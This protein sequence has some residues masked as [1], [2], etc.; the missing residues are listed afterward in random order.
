MPRKTAA[1]AAAA[2]VLLTAATGPG[3]GSDP[4]STGTP[5]AV[6]VASSA[7]P[8]GTAPTDPERFGRTPYERRLLDARRPTVDL[9]PVTGQR[10]RPNVLVLMLDDMRDDDLQFMPNVQRLVADQ[11]VRFTNTFSPQPLCCPARASFLTGLLSHNHH[12]WSHEDPFGFRVFDDRETLPRWL[13]ESGG[14]DTTFMGKYLNG[15]GRQRRLD[16]SESIR[17]VPPGWTDWRGSVDN[18]SASGRPELYGGTYKYFDTTLSNNGRLEPHQG[19]YQTQVFS[20]ITQ[21]VVRR[22]AGSPRP[23]FV[24]TAFAAPHV[25]GPGEEDDPEPFVRTDGHL[26]KFQSAA[27]PDYVKGRFD[28]R[29]TRLAPWIKREQVA[30]KPVF[31][32]N[33]PPMAPYEEDAVLADYRQRA[34]AVSVVDDE[35]ANI[36]ETLERSGE[37]DNTYVFVT[38]DNGYFL[39]EHRRRQGKIL[40]YDSS[41][42]VPL[43]MRG[44]GIPAGE[45]RTDPFLMVDFAPTILDA[46][47]VPA[48]ASMDGVSMLDVARDGDRGWRRPILT[49]SGPRKLSRGT[50]R[51]VTLLERE[52]GPSSLRFSQGVRTGRYLYVEHA[53]RDQ[54]LYDMARDPHQ[55]DNLVDLPRYRALRRTLAA[56]LDRL[57]TC[58][59]TECSR[60][61]P[62]RLWTDDPVPPADFDPAG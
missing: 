17:Y 31:I 50:L 47:G 2:L 6:A 8:A 61:M 44:P 39:G 59:G 23:F 46:T 4:G 54:E 43:V 56:E 27:R 48:G 58:A 11:G 62:R 13:H 30:A 51:R 52:H 37:L 16:G 28:H 9:S 10:D 45:E 35:V 19:R 34:E 20:D 60:P 49:E 36:M 7:G 42:R 3:G 14:Y 1:L 32:R 53:S 26:Q 40:P 5:D 15:Y 41:L 55:L 57:R 24:E 18:A 25:G 22:S 38:S 33:Q 12:V 29:I 21:D